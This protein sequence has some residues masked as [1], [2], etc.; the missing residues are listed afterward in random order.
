MVSGGSGTFINNN[1]ASSAD[2][3]DGLIIWPNC[4]AGR[5]NSLQ[6]PYTICDSCEIGQYKSTASGK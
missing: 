5:G 3:A 1:A 6:I 4:S 2:G